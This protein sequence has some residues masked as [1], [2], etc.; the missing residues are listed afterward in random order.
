[1]TSAADEFL[2]LVGLN[3]ENEIESYLSSKRDLDPLLSS[4]SLFIAGR[5]CIFEGLRV[6]HAESSFKIIWMNSMKSSYTS[7]WSSSTPI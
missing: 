4:N 3:A 7:Q 5:R 6:F 2:F 1:M